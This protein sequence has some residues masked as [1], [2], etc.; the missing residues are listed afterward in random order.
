MIQRQIQFRKLQNSV[1]EFG[2]LLS[3]NCA[4]QDLLNLFMSPLLNLVTSF[5]KSLLVPKYYDQ[6]FILN[7]AICKKDS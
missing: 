6:E 7:V 4:T 5:K 2:N 1:A 3:P